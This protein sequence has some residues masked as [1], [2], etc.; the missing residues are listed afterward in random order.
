M[1]AGRVRGGRG[2]DADAD[3]YAALTDDHEAAAHGE[4]LG[5]SEEHCA[6]DALVDNV[7]A[8]GALASEH[9]VHVL[10]LVVDRAVASQPQQ[11]LGFLCACAAR[12]V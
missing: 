9:L 3:A 4:V 7:D 2:A 1:P 11:Q 6:A 8:L 10:F 5:S 12:S